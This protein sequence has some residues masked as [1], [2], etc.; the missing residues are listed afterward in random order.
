[1]QSENTSMSVPVHAVVM[2][3]IVDIKG[4]GKWIEFWFADGKREPFNYDESCKAYLF[5]ELLAR[6]DL[7]EHVWK[8]GRIGLW[9]QWPK[10]S[11]RPLSVRTRL[12]A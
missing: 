7:S 9:V 1:M 4:D 10:G 2:R 3:Q 6:Y 8:H 12:S 5:D 11:D